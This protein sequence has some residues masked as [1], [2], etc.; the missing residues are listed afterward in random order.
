MLYMYTRSTC[1][2]RVV[3]QRGG[4]FSQ[5]SGPIFLS[6]LRHRHFDSAGLIT[7]GTQSRISNLPHQKLSFQHFF[8][9][10]L[11]FMRFIGFRESDSDSIVFSGL[12]CTEAFCC[13]WIQ[14]P[15]STSRSC[16][17]KSSPMSCDFCCVCAAGSSDSSPALS[18]SLAPLAL[19]R[20][21]V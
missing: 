2:I 8:L 17:G 20:L 4:F 6:C 9:K 18:A 10:K 3:F 13:R 12:W 21:A 14:A 11:R 16:G 19:T 15:T 1:L 7:M 5:G